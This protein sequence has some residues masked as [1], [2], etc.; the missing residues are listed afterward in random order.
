MDY[1]SN[2]KSKLFKNDVEYKTQTNFNTSFDTYTK[3][4]N[5]VGSSTGTADNFGETIASY[6]DTLVVG[7][8]ATDSNKGLAYIYVYQNNTWTLK[9][10]LN[11]AS[12]TA[13]HN[14]FGRG[15]SIYKDI[16]ICGTPHSTGESAY[17][18]TRDTVI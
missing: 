4:D 17:M 18:Y 6:D 10:T 9:Q 12:R 2:N 11:P 7:A 13:A 5:Q 8:Y 16:T 3:Y 14:F 15:V 1:Q